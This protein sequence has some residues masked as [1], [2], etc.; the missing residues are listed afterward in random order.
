[1]Y[2]PISISAMDSTQNEINTVQVIDHSS[3][4]HYIPFSKATQTK[5]NTY[6]QNFSQANFVNSTDAHDE[7]LT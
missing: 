7:V 4:L 2:I 1:M 5:E 6:F 3:K